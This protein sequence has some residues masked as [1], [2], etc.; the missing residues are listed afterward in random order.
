MSALEKQLKP[1]NPMKRQVSWESMAN[2]L[3]EALRTPL[4]FRGQSKE[5]STLYLIVVLTRTQHKGAKLKRKTLYTKTKAMA[6][7]KRKS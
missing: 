6:E 2:V 4:N 5:R 1:T 7:E 3:Y